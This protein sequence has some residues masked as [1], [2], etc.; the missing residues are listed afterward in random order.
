MFVGAIGLEPTNLTDVNREGK[1]P[2]YQ[3]H[4]WQY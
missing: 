4:V 3:P 1:K 2:I